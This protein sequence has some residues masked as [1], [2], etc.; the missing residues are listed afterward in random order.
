M[1]FFQ[2]SPEQSRIVA[3]HNIWIFPVAALPVTVIVMLLWYVWLRI[4]AV[5]W[6]PSTRNRAR[7]SGPTTW[8]EQEFELPSLREEIAS[9]PA[10][11]RLT[12]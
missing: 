2:Y 12:G 10:Y 4:Q 3:S 11:T 5:K 7:K 9:G 8:P 1:N 6:E